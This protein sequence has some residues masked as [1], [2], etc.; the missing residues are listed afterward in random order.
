MVEDYINWKVQRNPTTY[1]I[2]AKNRNLLNLI[3]TNSRLSLKQIA[4]EMHISKV[5]VFNRIK[6]L[7]EQKIITGYSCFIDL[8]KLGFKTYQ[9]GIKLNMGIEE[10][11]MYVK[12]LEDCR[13]VNQIIKLNGGRWDLLIRIVTN[14]EFFDESMDSIMD[15]KIER[16]DIIEL[17][18]ALC[19]IQNQLKEFYTLDKQNLSKKDIQLLYE[20]AKNSKQKII[21]LSNKLD[22]SPNTIIRDMKSL[23][24]NKIILCYVTE[25]NPFIY[26]D[27]A[28]MFFITTKDKKV[29]KIL[30]KELAQIY[31][32]GVL[33]SYQ[34]P[35][36]ISL[37]LVS[38]LEQLK[39]VEEIV[40]KYIDKIK[41]YEIVRVEEQTTYYYFP[42]VLYDSLMK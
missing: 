24:K 19:M 33:I 5:A 38:N 17:K 31:S 22:S 6:K 40:K 25:F 32:T 42:K 20:L 21:D 23:E 7:E 14:D 39:Q 37:H 9:I 30:S 41:F 1:K 36:I 26:G 2:S 35:D 4:K 3:H 29:Q 27:E 8:G 34:Y 11:E 12:K 10:R 18:K 13:F 28:Y 15:D 16:Y